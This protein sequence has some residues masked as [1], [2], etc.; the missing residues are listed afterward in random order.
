MF[1]DCRKTQSTN[2]GII[3]INI[4]AFHFASILSPVKCW[5]VFRF[6]FFKFLL[7]EAF[8]EIYRQIIISIF[9]YLF[10]LSKLLFWFIIFVQ[11]IPTVIDLSHVSCMKIPN[12]NWLYVTYIGVLYTYIMLLEYYEII[13]TFRLCNDTN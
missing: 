4:F 9:F 3:T 8:G 1:W 10:G 6:F 11:H 5:L 13:L 2:N 12:K 7:P